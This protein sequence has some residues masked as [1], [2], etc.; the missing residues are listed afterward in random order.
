[1]KYNTM[2]LVSLLD[3]KVTAAVTKVSNTKNQTFFASQFSPESSTY[4]TKLIFTLNSDFG[5][6]IITIIS[7]ET[8]D[9]EVKWQ[10]QSHTCERNQGSN[11]EHLAQL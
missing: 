8:Q 6:D 4:I 9:T 3:R 7:S 11:C 10:S 5:L 2:S 1:M